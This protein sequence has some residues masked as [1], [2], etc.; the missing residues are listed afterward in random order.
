MDVGVVGLGSGT[1]ASYARPGD[2]WKFYEINPGVIRLSREPFTY[3]R[4]ASKVATVEI[5]EGDGRLG[6]ARDSAA[7]FDVLVIDAFSSDSIPIHLLTRE[8]GAIYQS[9]L[10]D[11]GIL[12]V[13]IS[14]RTLDLEPVVRGL[15]QANGFESLRVN[16][17]NDVP[18][19]VSAAS[20]MLLSKSPDSLEALRSASVKFENRPAIVWRDGYADV[21]GVIGLG[22]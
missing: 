3:L 4:N 15:A 17:P 21:I 7:R 12:A 2:R 11:G 22:N 16:N 14:N 10:K 5:V 18:N 1:L 6:L 8:C 19:G 20:W 13:H 9:R